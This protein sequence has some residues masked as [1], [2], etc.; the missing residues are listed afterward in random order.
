MNISIFSAQ[1]AEATVLSFSSHKASSSKNNNNKRTKQQQKKKQQRK[2]NSTL[3]NLVIQFDAGE[4]KGRGVAQIEGIPD[5][6]SLRVFI[7][8][9][10]S[11]A[12]FLL[13][14]SSLVIASRKLGE[15]LYQYSS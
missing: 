9:V 7:H 13:K 11:T 5:K 12:S 2:V 1:P 15:T 6:G 10:C 8:C 14:F 3:G 4:E